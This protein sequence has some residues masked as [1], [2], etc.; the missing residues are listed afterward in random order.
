M[1]STKFF[2]LA[3]AV[4]LAGASAHAEALSDMSTGGQYVDQ[5][6]APQICKSTCDAH[7]N[8]DWVHKTED[9]IVCSVTNAYGQRLASDS[10]LATNKS[11]AVT[12][13]IELCRQ[14]AEKVAWN[15]QFANYS[16][17]EG[18]SV[19]GCSGEFVD[20][21]PNTINKAPEN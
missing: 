11:G 13:A 9:N 21:Y 15:G 16:E 1:K 3:A 2:V 12:P 19:C 10:G 6:N 20:W 4:S 14:A 17:A 18:G 8:G 5:F 7:F